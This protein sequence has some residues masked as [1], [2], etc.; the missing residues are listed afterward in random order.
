MTCNKRTSKFSTGQPGNCIDGILDLDVLAIGFDESFEAP[1][2]TGH[3]DTVI[4][5]NAVSGE[6]LRLYLQP[7]RYVLEYSGI[8]RMVTLKN[9]KYTY[10]HSFKENVGTGLWSILGLS[11]KEIVNT[12]HSTS[13]YQLVHLKSDIITIT[14]AKYVGYSHGILMTNPLDGPAVVADNN[15]I[16][17]KL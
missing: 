13:S 5:Y 12:A 4:A 2:C 8:F 17:Y 14:T 11:K 10:Y 16:V 7:G 3:S 15:F 9:E 6:Y 1:V